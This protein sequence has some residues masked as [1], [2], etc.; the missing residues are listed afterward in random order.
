MAITKTLIANGSKEHHKFTLNVTEDRTSGNSSFNSFSFIL[1]PIKNGYDWYGWNNKISYEI[2]IDTKTFTGTI[3]QYNGTSTVIL[4]SSSGIEIPHNEDGTK[5]IGIS[6]KV[7]DTTGASYTCG[8]ASASG[9]MELSELHK[10]PTVTLDS[11]VEK[12]QILVNAGVP[13]TTFVPRL[14]I[15]E[16][17]ISAIPYDD[18][19]ITE[20]RVQNS[21][22]II[23]YES[24]SPVG[25][26]LTKNELMWGY[27]QETG[28]P[29]SQWHIYVKDNKGARGHLLWS[30]NTVIPYLKP[31]LIQTASSVKRNG[32]ISGKVNLNLTG[33]FYND[34]I[35]NK[36]NTISLSYK[37]WK[38]GTTEPDTYI[39]IPS[40]VY[41]ISGNNVSIA[42]WNVTKNGNIVE[43]VDKSGIYL[44]KI[45]AIDAFGCE[46]EEITLTC[47]KGEW[48]MAK[49][50]DR[51]DFK[52]ITQ[53]GQS[54]ATKSDT[55]K[56]I[57]SACV[58]NEYSLSVTAWA[59]YR[60]KINS[61]T[62]IGDKLSF[63]STNNCIVIGDGVSKIQMT[64]AVFFDGTTPKGQLRA[65]CQ[66]RNTDGN[67][68]FALPAYQYMSSGTPIIVN[69]PPLILN[70]SPGEVVELILQTG[71]SGTA[72]ILARGTSIFVEVIE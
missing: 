45:K 66:V 61:A 44:F 68:R 13:G 22:G 38:K 46:S 36:S 10:A 4:S 7:T 57:V 23:A 17:N 62:V 39:T 32:Q 41:T 53:Q 11:V 65:W 6:F 24:T 3:P 35:G 5:T 70:V 16:F 8:N 1:A 67:A 47:P 58:S 15:K 71:A 63:D 19:T 29:I 25:V 27:E 33:T 55:Q 64:G 48:L 30:D 52:K 49:F 56:H 69:V 40:D 60:A 42:N 43:D 12:N 72:K 9:T 20:Y 2:K 54:V 21:T 34:K 18:A 50:K 51:V 37:Y 28:K 26:D 14:S 59:S 31:N